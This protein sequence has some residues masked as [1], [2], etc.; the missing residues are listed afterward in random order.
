MNPES[1]KSESAKPRA[2][3]LD[4]DGVL[5]DTEPVHMRAWQEVLKAQSLALTSQDFLTRFFGLN[6]RD[7]LSRFFVQNHR[8]LPHELRSQLIAE[9]EKNSKK[10]LAEAI[11]LI[12]GVHEFLPAAAKKYPLALVTGSLPGEVDFVLRK[13]GWKNYFSVIVTA[14]D[15]KEGKPSPEGFLKAFD[16][17]ASSYTWNPPLQKSD[18][19]ILEDSDH[20]VA[21]AQK[22]GIPFLRV[23]KT[24]AGIKFSQS[25]GR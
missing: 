22:A 12:E 16:R 9:K 14:A 23:A 15:V 3:L 24:L 1:V 7:F 2:L 18:C 21:A 8:E 10:F 25:S 5:V 19:L 20:G 4:F 6:D 11:P 13:L 17:L